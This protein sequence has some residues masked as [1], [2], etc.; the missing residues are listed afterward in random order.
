RQ[1]V[2]ARQPFDW[3]A[4]ECHACHCGGNDGI[5][6]SGDQAH[7]TCTTRDIFALVPGCK[8]YQT[9]GQ[10]GGIRRCVSRAWRTGA[11]P[12]FYEHAVW[13]GEHASSHPLHHAWSNGRRVALA[14]EEARECVDADQGQ[15]LQPLLS[16]QPEKA[17]GMAHQQSHA[18]R[19]FR[20]R[21]AE[22]A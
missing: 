17:E 15:T 21:S 6:L 20:L 18:V 5:L 9:F 11:L 3:M 8:V 19:Y 2:S 16:R 13:I 4:L 7:G 1:S 22:I 10:R 12:E 14:F